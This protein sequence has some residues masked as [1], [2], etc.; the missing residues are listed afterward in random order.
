GISPRRGDPA[1]SAISTAART[2]PSST[3][4]D[5]V[6]PSHVEADLEHVAVDD[7]VVLPLDPQPAL[8]LRLGPRA[9]VEEV[10][11][12]DHLGPDE[13]ALEVGVDHARAFGR[14][15]TRPERPRARF[16]VAGGA[17]AAP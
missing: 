7:L 3:S 17:D 4:Q 6:V 1:V 12:E 5:I 9:D 11:P 10:L 16:G 2:S 13:A 15:G 8:F 14:L